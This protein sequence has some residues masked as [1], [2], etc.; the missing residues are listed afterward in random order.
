MTKQMVHFRNF[1]NAP[2][3]QSVSRPTKVRKFATPHQIPFQVYWFILRV[4]GWKHSLNFGRVSPRPLKKVW[5]EEFPS[6]T[7]EVVQNLRVEGI[8]A[9][10][11]NCNQLTRI[12]HLQLLIK[13]NSSSATVFSPKFCHPSSLIIIIT[14]FADHAGSSGNVFDVYRLGFRPRSRN[15]PRVIWLCLFV[16]PLGVSR[17]MPTEY[18]K[19]GQGHYLLKHFQTIFHPS[20]CL[21]TMRSLSYWQIRY[22]NQ[23]N[24]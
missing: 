15:G 6:C 7:I 18:Y 5:G 19:L 3:N 1:T 14:S 11:F 16:I 20:S 4:R 13:R 8:H 2:N 17:Q 22:Y 23:I 12:L 24:I 9:V 21:S 10:L